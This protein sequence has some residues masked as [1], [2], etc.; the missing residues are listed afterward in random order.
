MN[1]YHLLF[2]SA[3]YKEL[4]N[5]PSAVSVIILQRIEELVYNPFP[6]RMTKLSGA[7]GTY[8][9]RVRDYRILYEVDIAAK[10][11]IIV[12]IKHRRDAYRNI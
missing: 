9:I 11:V 6:P 10:R 3:A 4:Y 2:N 12:K 1:E 5:L 8:R 7:Y